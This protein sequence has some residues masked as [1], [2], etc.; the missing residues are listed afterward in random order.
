MA[1]LAG[2]PDVSRQD[3]RAVSLA[4][5]SIPDSLTLCS[6]SGQIDNYLQHLQASGSPSY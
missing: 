6:V 1:R 2:A 3:P 5:S 4:A